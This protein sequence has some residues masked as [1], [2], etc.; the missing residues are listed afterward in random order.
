MAPDPKFLCFIFLFEYLGFD[1][2]LGW[3]VQKLY[4]NVFIIHLTFSFLF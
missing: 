4:R 1:L 3:G 2:L